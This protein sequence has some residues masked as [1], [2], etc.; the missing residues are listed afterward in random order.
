MAAP[1][2]EIQRFRDAATRFI[3]NLRD[4][5]S[6]LAVLEDH[7]VDDAARQAFFQAEFGA[8]TNNPD[9]TW[10]QFAAGFVALRAIR[11]TRDAQKIALAKLLR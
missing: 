8:G 7:G 11:T 10:S 6:I 9:I 1:A 5:D 2:I 3:D 4:I